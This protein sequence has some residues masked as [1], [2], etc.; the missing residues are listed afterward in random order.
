MSSVRPRIV[1]LRDFPPAVLEALAEFGEV[2]VSPGG[3]VLRDEAAIRQV[4]AAD[5]LLVSPMDRVT[6]Q[7]L[8]AAPRLRAI[9]SASAG[10]DH[11]DLSTCRARKIAVANAPDETTEPTADLAFGLI[12]AAAR[13]L[14]AADRFV[15][16]G[17][18][19]V[20]GETFWGLDVHHRTLG[21]I[22]FGRI[23][24]AI[25]R[26]AHGFSMP[27]LY[28]NRRPL[29]DSDAG[30]ASWRTLD[31]LLAESDF[32]VLQVPLT[33]ETRHMIGARELALMKPTA[34][35]INTGRGGVIDEEALADALE[36]KAIWQAAL[37]VFETE[38]SP[39]PRL[40]N[41]PNLVAAPHIGT[42]TVASRAA[43][44]AQAVS[45]LKALLAV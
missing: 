45:N 37:D 6:A 44:A 1:L 26:R 14:P 42:A 34:V 36:A 10:L 20:G 5:A 31:A 38:P 40:L 3:E 33:E 27:V 19:R 7:M 32:V 21:I 12:L 35:L 16:S 11:I 18:W 30:G 15:R 28:H 43:M 22:G 24:Q 23:G 2:L 8:A 41:C 39:L 25:A 13:R 17:D 4:A 29:P 9:S